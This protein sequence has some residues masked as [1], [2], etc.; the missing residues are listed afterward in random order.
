MPKKV[1]VYI[2]MLVIGCLLL[3][4]SLTVEL[5]NPVKWAFLALA[6]LL[7]ITSAAVFMKEGIRQ[8]KPNQ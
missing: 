8:M 2:L 4:L 5:P 1:S 3:V 7:N 6:L